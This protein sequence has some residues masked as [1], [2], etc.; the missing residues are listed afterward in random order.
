MQVNKLIN[1]I[2]PEL[3]GLEQTL[4]DFWQKISRGEFC[5]HDAIFQKTRK[6]LPE[7]NRY[8][9]I[10]IFHRTDNISDIHSLQESIPELLPAS[11]AFPSPG[12]NA[13]VRTDFRNRSQ[14]PGLLSAYRGNRCRRSAGSHIPPQ[15]SL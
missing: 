15:V 7:C 11:V 12:G 5:G 2:A 4:S 6:I 1:S 13:P 3:I 8:Y 9:R 10:L 14:A